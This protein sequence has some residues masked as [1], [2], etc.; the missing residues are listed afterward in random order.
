[1]EKS[2]NPLSFTALFIGAFMI[3]GC[4]SPAVT[5]E[6]AGPVAEAADAP[7]L[8]RKIDRAIELVA[9]FETSPDLDADWES[10][11]QG[12]VYAPATCPGWTEQLV[13]DNF[14]K[15]GAPIPITAFSAPIDLES[16][17]DVTP[18]TLEPKSPPDPR[19]F[20]DFTRPEDVLIKTD[21][22]EGIPFSCNAYSCNATILA[23][24]MAYS[25]PG[26]D[27]IIN[28]LAEAGFVHVFGPQTIFVGSCRIA[29]DY[30]LKRGPL[31]D[32]CAGQV[33]QRCRDPD[34]S[35]EFYRLEDKMALFVGWAPR[36]IARGGITLDFRRNAPRPQ[37]LNLP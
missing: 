2:V 21:P 19:D 27:G 34:P 32:T 4:R 22:V 10:L 15:S 25:G 3:A 12:V 29:S 17:D 9:L 18:E 20:L 1:M 33:L 30:E 35:A 7:T 14:S 24:H 13:L 16:A 26:V 6:Q 36:S 28:V 31:A 5:E 37:R 23:R 11:P 8:K